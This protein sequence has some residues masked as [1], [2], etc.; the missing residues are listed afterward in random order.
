MVLNKLK[1]GICDDMSWMEQFEN[2]EIEH[3]S[4]SF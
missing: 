3:S 2:T 4:F 1:V